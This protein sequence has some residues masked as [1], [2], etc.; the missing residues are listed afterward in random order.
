MTGSLAL[1]LDLY[2][3]RV[4]GVVVLLTS[5][6]SEAISIMASSTS[7]SVV[8][9]I[10]FSYS[11]VSIFWSI[12]DVTKGDYDYLSGGL[13]YKFAKGRS[14]VLEMHEVS[15]IILLSLR[16][17]FSESVKSVTGLD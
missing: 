6:L 11:F 15:G 5:L 7:N 8:S 12:C 13:S 16:P 9:S 2:R 1:S 14:N 17:Q 3:S 4:L 10:G